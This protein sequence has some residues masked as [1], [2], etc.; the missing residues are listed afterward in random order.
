MSR[1]DSLNSMPLGTCRTIGAFASRDV[2]ATALLQQD[3]VEAMADLDIPDDD[4]ARRFSITLLPGV[5]PHIVLQYRTSTSS[6]REYGGAG[7]THPRYRH[8]ATKLHS[9]IVTVQAPGPVGLVIARLK[10]DMAARLLGDRMAAFMD[11]KIALGDLINPNAVDLLEDMVSEARS[12]AARFEIMMRFL[13]AHA[14]DDTPDALSA[15]V[16][17]RLRCNPLARIRQ[18]ADDASV[19]ERH[20]S[21][22]FRLAFGT[23]PKHFARMARFERLLAAR[24]SERS[25]AGLACASGFADQAHMI[26]DFRD[27]VGAPPE[28]VL[29]AARAPLHGPSEPR[30][31]LMW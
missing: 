3:L 30:P 9:G 26:N 12:S 18:L 25:W 6:Y 29:T 10:P 5:A 22:R 11:A 17:R 20:L 13:R 14:R 2:S 16:A 24:A 19:S 21:R 28:Q 1:L 4:A 31:I 8:V 7:R 23:S 15:H 27:I